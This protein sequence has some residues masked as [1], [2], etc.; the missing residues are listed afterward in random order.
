MKMEMPNKYHIDFDNKTSFIEVWK[1]LSYVTYNTLYIN[2]HS[3]IFIPPA[4]FAG[5]YSDP[6]VRPFVR[7][8]DPIS[9]PL[10]L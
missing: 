4:K 10:L 1:I 2:E 5:I 6:Y 7:P 9:N 8:S 3:I